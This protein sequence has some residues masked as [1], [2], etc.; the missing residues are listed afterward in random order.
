M[1]S[2]FNIFQRNNDIKDKDF[3]FDMPHIDSLASN[4]TMYHWHDFLEIS[5][6]IK[7]K[8]TYFIEDKLIPVKAGDIIII[9]NAERHRL[10]YD[11]DPLYETVIHF[12]EDILQK[13]IL[14][15]HYKELLFSN[16][17]DVTPEEKKTLVEIIKTI[18]REFLLKEPYYEFL[19]IAQLSMFVALVQ[20]YNNMISKTV[21]TKQKIHNVERLERILSFIASDPDLDLD[22]TAVAK[23]FHLNPSYFSQYF[24]KNMGI[25]YSEYIR[26]LRVGRAIRLLKDGKTNLI[27]VA[28]LSGYNS[29]SAFYNAFAKATGTSPKKFLDYH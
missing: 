8:A 23:H 11:E 27:D 5:L 20:R 22:Q 12:A 6:I 2:E 4:M 16:K 14:L 28:Y 29:P 13:N 17:L 18:Q 9:N 19:I 3:H 26:N 7:G 15:F 24:K 25:S 21:I 1:I 10:E